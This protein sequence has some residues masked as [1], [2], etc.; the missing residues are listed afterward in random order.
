MEYKRLLVG[1]DLTLMDRGII[2]YAG[3]LSKILKPDKVIFVHVVR[4]VD[5]EKSEK[6]DI[7]VQHELQRKKISAL[8][9]DLYEDI[10]YNFPNVENYDFDCLVLEG[11]PVDEILSLAR[12]KNIDLI[13]LGKKKELRGNGVVNEQLTRK[14]PCSVWF[15]PERHKLKLNEIFVCNDFST[16]SKLG[17]LAAIELAKNNTNATIF[18]QHVIAGRPAKKVSVEKDQAAADEVQNLKEKAT[19][20]YN[21]FLSS[22]DNHAVHISPLFNVDSQAAPH[23]VLTEMAK[24]K[25]ADLIVIGSRSRSSNQPK[26]IGSV[27]EKL[28][29]ENTEVPMLVVKTKLHIEG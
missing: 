24:K 15:L 2:Q 9:K 23:V 28:L 12:K 27:T 7:I 10:E 17:L 4:P 22:I 13:L 16:F 3:F 18:S 20:Q 26:I 21:K 11:T 6:N 29:R 14:I 8:K 1:L 25:R 19:E 5:Y